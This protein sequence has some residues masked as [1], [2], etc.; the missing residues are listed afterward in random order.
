V[1]KG[2]K[3]LTLWLVVDAGGLVP[4]PASHLRYRGK[5]PPMSNSY[6]PPLPWGEPTPVQK[7]QPLPAKKPL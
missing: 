1:E 3:A 7:S 6:S 5:T 2:A 4:A